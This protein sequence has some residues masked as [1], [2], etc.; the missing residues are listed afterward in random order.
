[1]RARSR[2]VRSLAKH[3]KTM[4]GDTRAWSRYLMDDGRAKMEGLVDGSKRRS[5][6]DWLGGRC[7]S[8]LAVIGSLSY[9][10][11]HDVR[12]S[13]GSY[14]AL[15]ELSPPHY[16]PPWST[17]QIGD[18][19]VKVAKLLVHCCRP[20]WISSLSFRTSYCRL[21]AVTCL[22]AQLLLGQWSAI[23]FGGNTALAVREDEAPYKLLS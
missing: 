13:T 23:F 5:L 7:E 12:R 20:R 11:A 19:S 14:L 1:M 10:P 9:C 6:R 4:R 18:P 22:L 3:S 21:S 2:T 16:C 17:A 8:P 15:F